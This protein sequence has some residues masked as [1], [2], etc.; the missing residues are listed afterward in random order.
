MCLH[1]FYCVSHFLYANEIEIIEFLYEYQEV[2]YP[3]ME[4][5]MAPESLATLSVSWLVFVIL[6][7]CWLMMHL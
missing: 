6:I 3:K 2:Y 7:M 5:Y 1:A 4:M